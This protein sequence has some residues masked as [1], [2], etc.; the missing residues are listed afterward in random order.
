MTAP[1]GC[2]LVLLL[3]LSL[4]GASWAQSSCT[5]HAAIPGIPGIPGAPGSNGKPGTP[6]TKGEKG[7]P[8]LAGDHGE[9]GEKGDP[10]MPGKP[11]K[12]GPKGPIG[13]KGSPGPPGPRGPKGESGDYR[14]TQK[15]AFSATR[16][17]NSVLRREQ[18]I[19]F[20]HVITNE[21]RNYEPRSGKF[22]CTVPGIYYFAYHASS[23][24]N[25]CV[26][27]IRGRERMEKVVT[28]CDYA[29]NTFQV[30][31]GGV[32]LKLSEGENV[33]LQ[34]TD[35]NALL[36]L[37]GANSIFSGFLLFPDAEV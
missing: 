6:G 3:L 33:F 35:K 13:P 17:I 26:N 11:G 29:Q 36:G 21:N 12:V 4:S 32:V 28:F 10:G 8:G 7:L 2:V 18:P 31:T 34:A 19:R 37:E 20:D 30:T 15:I 24:G 27:L 23:R 14:A 22:T 5:G 25:L 1:R 16:T 9:F